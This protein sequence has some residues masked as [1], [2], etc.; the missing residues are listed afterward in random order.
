MYHSLNELKSIGFVKFRV[1]PLT[2][3]TNGTT[4]NNKASIYFDFNE[5]ILTN[6]A[7]TKISSIVVTPVK[8]S[9]YEVRSKISSGKQKQVLNFWTTLTELNTSHFN[10]QRSTDGNQFITFGKVIAKGVGT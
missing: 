7:I 2:T 6:T 8:I 5:P 10:I 9:K 3:I 1:K 4:I